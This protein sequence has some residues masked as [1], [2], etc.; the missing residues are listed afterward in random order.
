MDIRE[1]LLLVLRRWKEV[2]ATGLLLLL[3]SGVWTHFFA[4]TK[5]KST[6][7]FTVAGEKG[8]VSL[9]EDIRGADLFSETVQGW[10]KNP[11]LIAEIEELAGET[12]GISGRV[13]ENE[14]VVVELSANSEEAITK[15]S[16]ST[17]AILQDKVKQF[18]K[19]TRHSFKLSVPTIKYE[20]SEPK[21]GKNEVIFLILGLLI[22][23]A[24]AFLYEFFA[25]K[26]SFTHQIEEALG[27]KIAGKGKKTASILK[28]Q[29]KK[30]DEIVLIK[31]GKT[32]LE[33]LRSIKVGAKGKIYPIIIK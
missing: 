9:F 3:L 14:N 2:L 5:Y 24:V 7:F 6:L 1:Y 33:K 19:D 15:V 16:E 25:D 31:L 30:T 23:I 29:L 18:N 4:E 22:G 10:T 12:F 26:A 13:Q 28:K 17:L 21:L 11:G 32:S 27:E 20:I 8:S